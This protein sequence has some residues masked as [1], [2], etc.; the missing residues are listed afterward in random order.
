MIASY[1]NANTNIVENIIMADAKIDNVPTGYFL[2]NIA[3]NIS[4]DIGY[5]YDVSS[6]TFVRV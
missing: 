4:C 1:I 5:T 3:E 6:N 2:V